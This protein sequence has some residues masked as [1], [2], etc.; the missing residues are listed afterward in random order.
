MTQACREIGGRYADTR[1]YCIEFDEKTKTLDPN[2]N[3]VLIKCLFGF[4]DR[5][6]REQRMWKRRVYRHDFST[7]KT[8]TISKSES[9]HCR[10][11]G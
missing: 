5:N 2:A 1:V 3:G 10:S 4:M 6:G 9:Y 8:T 11:T 7:P